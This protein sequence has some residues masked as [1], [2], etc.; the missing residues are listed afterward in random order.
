M[1]PRPVEM[2]KLLNDLALLPNVSNHPKKDA[3]Q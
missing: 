2:L 1:M 3:K